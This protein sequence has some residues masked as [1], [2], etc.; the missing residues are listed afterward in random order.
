M[1]TKKKLGIWMDHASA[2]VIEIA[3][4]MVTKIV[5]SESTPEEK[6]KSLQKGESMM[7]N[8]EQQQQIEYYKKLGA[9]IK[10]YDEVLLF[11]PTNAKIELLNILKADL[12][13]SKIKIEV[14]QTDKMTQNQEHAYVREYFSKIEEN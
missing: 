5:V 3:D 14:R 12:S 7:H 2:H 4:P 10:D 1:T 11:G 8:K 13:F 9:I 6:E